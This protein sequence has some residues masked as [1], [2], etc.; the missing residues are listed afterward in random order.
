MTTIRNHVCD[1]CMIPANLAREIAK[2]L[3]NVLSAEVMAD[4][5]HSC[6]ASGVASENPG[7]TRADA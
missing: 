1:I 7:M 4:A 6:T 5:R 2:L 3:V